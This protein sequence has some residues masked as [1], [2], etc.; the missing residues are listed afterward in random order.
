[1]EI[2][3]QAPAFPTATTGG[4]AEL[5]CY[6]W[7]DNSWVPSRKEISVTNQPPTTSSARVGRDPP[8]AAYSIQVQTGRGSILAE[9]LTRSTFRASPDPV[10]GCR[11]NI[12]IKAYP[13]HFTGSILKALRRLARL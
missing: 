12:E 7:T 6:M 9:L 3:K 5:K 8:T 1:M 13:R 2:I 4:L 10:T 11:Q